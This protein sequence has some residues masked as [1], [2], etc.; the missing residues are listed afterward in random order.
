MSI[1]K[2]IL[3]AQSSEQRATTFQDVWG[4][5]LDS[6]GAATAAGKNVT[7]ETAMQV[8]TVFACIRIISDNV[9]TLPLELYLQTPQARER[10][11]NV[12]EWAKFGST[13]GKIDFINQLAV[14][15]L[16]DGNA[17]AAT[18][19]DGQ[20][21]IIGLQV[22]DPETVEVKKVGGQAVYL[23]NGGSPLSSNDILHVPGM[24]FP[25]SLTG[26]SPITYARESISLSL[27]ATEYGAKFFGGGALPGMVVEVPG[28][29]SEVGIK[30]LKRG[31]NDAHAG[32]GNAHKLA[33][34][35]EGAQFSKVTIDPDDAQFLQTRQFQVT[36][37]TRIFGVPPHLVGDSSNSTS[38]G[39]GLAQQNTTFVQH[40][41][42]PLVER[43]EAGLNKLI[44]SEGLPPGVFVKLA[45]DGLLRGDTQQR[46][47]GYATGLAS[48]F[49]TINEVRDWEELP[50]LPETAQGGTENE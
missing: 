23:I 11:P 6:F 30:A 12:P 13:V 45:L 32:A 50:P 41:L 7:T 24:M 2:R 4:K 47:D 27:A 15:I 31:W 33:V 3:G 34:L 19:R 10:Y 22:L 8:S 21:R 28:E 48:G 49:Y 44:S 36:D 5:N 20:N 35:T 38:W 1:I 46:L 16:T 18:F 29:L 43:I 9:S 37:I 14:S 39:S 25:A 26:I 42:R 17:Y 40:T